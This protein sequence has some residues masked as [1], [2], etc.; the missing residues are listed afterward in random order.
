MVTYRGKKYDG[1]NFAARHPG[2]SII[3]A[4]NGRDVE[5]VW[6]EHGVG[7]HK[8]TSYILEAIKSWPEV[9]T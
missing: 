2:G 9:T 7:W 8:D 4:A 1:T 6:K 5:E 3:W